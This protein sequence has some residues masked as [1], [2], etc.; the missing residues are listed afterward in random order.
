[1][2]KYV[3][4]RTILLH[5]FIPLSYI[6]S[7]SQ[8]LYRFFFGWGGGG[9]RGKGCLLTKKRRFQLEFKSKKS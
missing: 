1:M 2:L 8:S 9:G 4:L 3:I 5:L 6:L 7:Y